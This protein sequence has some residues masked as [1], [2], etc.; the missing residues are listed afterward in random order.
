MESE[1]SCVDWLLECATMTSRR[2]GTIARSF[3]RQN[4]NV[5]WHP[6]TRKRGG[7]LFSV[8]VTSKQEEERR[9]GDGRTDDTLFYRAVPNNTRWIISRTNANL[10]TRAVDDRAVLAP[11][12]APRR[13]RRQN[14]WRRSAHRLR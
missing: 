5:R 11:L 1:I 9:R 12:R 4:S 7:R 2:T 3:R 13:Y 8:L 14:G 10:N 6:G